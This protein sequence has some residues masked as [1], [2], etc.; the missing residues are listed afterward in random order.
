MPPK[1]NP[2]DTNFQ[3]WDQ[4]NNVSS[5]TTEIIKDYRNDERFHLKK[6][7]RMHLFHP[8]DCF[9][10]NNR[11]IRKLLIKFS[12]ESNQKYHNFIYS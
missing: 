11:S 10:L 8:L 1:E 2:R 6:N 7:S 3:V 5:R 4:K 9:S 12:F